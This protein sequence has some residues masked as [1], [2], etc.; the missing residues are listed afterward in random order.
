[1][2]GDTVALYTDGITESL[3]ETGEEFGDQRL[4]DTLR[5]DRA[6]PSRALEK[7]ILDTVRRFSPHEQY[8][9]LTLIV[10]KGK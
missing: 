10:A 8:D 1:M 2:P 4:I 6:A 9:D 7:T 3:N 5:Q